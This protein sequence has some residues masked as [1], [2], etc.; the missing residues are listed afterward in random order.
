MKENLL[1]ARVLRLIV[2]IGCTAYSYIPIKESWPPHK[3]PIWATA[4]A[5][6]FLI[7]FFWIKNNR[8]PQVL[9]GVGTIFGTISLLF[10][11][12]GG[13]IYTLPAVVLMIYVLI[14]SFK[15]P[16]SAPQ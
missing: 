10:S 2:A 6:Y 9:V 7:L 14:L 11:F 5:S 13:L 16:E 15:E 3:S 1:T 4:W 8:A 12:F